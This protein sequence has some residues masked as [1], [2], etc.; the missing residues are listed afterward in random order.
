MLGD[1]HYVSTVLIDLTPF[2]ILQ[3][4]NE[5]LCLCHTSSTQQLYSWQTKLNGEV[6]LCLARELSS[7]SL[8]RNN[9]ELPLVL[10]PHSFR[11]FF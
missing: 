4:Q 1:S 9:R 11:L 5:D 10:I 2:C 3:Y 8:S 7:L 6:A